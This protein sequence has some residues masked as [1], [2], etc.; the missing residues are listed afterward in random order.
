MNKIE[1]TVESGKM[2]DF[3]FPSFWTPEEETYIEEVMRAIEQ[4][5]EE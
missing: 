3:N 1:H 2:D 4:E 5:M